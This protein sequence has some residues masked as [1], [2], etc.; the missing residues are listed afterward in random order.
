M[1]RQWKSDLVKSGEK[2]NLF[3]FKLK[4][5]NERY[6]QNPLMGQNVGEE[7]WPS[8]TKNAR[9]LSI[10]LQGSALVFIRERTSTDRLIQPGV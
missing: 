10:T 4:I 2:S 9:E 7:F 3:F 1:V 8:S 5:P 6:I